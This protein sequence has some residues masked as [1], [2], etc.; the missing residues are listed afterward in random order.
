MFFLLQ[1]V[2][3]KLFLPLVNFFTRIFKSSSFSFQIF[4]VCKSV[5]RQ[6]LSFK[7]CL[8]SEN[9][10]SKV[11]S[12]SSSDS[13]ESTNHLFSQIKLEFSFKS[14]FQVTF[15]ILFLKDIFFIS[16]YMLESNLWGSSS[17]LSKRNNIRWSEKYLIVNCHET[18]IC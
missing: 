7:T 10:F 6:I 16:L 4:I 14:L 8:L 1:V 15:Q 18:D 11:S 13:I 3:S 9:Y 5:F 12:S 17:K 2:F